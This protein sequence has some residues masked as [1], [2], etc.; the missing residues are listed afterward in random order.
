M[1]LFIF[2]TLTGCKAPPPAPEGLDDSVQFI[3]QEFYADDL[4]VGAG[5]TGLVDWIE[6]EGEELLGKDAD[7]ESAGA[8]SL[9]NLAASDVSHLDMTWDGVEPA[10]ARGVVALAEMNCNWTVA[11]DLLIR[12]DQDVV[13]EGDFDSYDRSFIGDKAT[14]LAASSDEKFDSV[15]DL[16]DP[17]SAEFDAN[18][19][20]DT[21]LITENEVQSTELGV[22]IPF[23]LHLHFRHGIFEIQGEEA[24]ASMIIGFVPEPASAEGG[25]NSMIQN[26][27]VE[28]N[29]DRGDKTLR[30]FANWTQIESPFVD[31]ES[32]LVAVS[33]VNK[34][35]KSAQRLS[36]ICAGEI[37]L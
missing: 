1:P 13:F 23:D 20:A 6:S 25:K 16:Y 12:P 5:L 26:Y 32:P 14:Y 37:E 31:T 29:L 3:L 19:Y 34:A 8:F 11:E 36:E 2:L 21:L 28:V 33:A 4:T 22:T 24:P 15:K 18:D 35:Q 17:T 30:V 7:L 10:D 9:A 27:S